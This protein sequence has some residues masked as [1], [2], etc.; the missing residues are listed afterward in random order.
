MY[1]NVG[2]EDGIRIC[3]GRNGDGDTRKEECVLV[4][5]V[6]TLLYVVFGGIKTVIPGGKS[7]SCIWIL[8]TILVY[9]ITILKCCKWKYLF[10]YYYYF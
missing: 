8:G 6:K 7:C 9:V 1:F 4:W 2:R 5:K 3:F 10:F